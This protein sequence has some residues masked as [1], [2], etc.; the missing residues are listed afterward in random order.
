MGSIRDDGAQSNSLR[1]LFYL[2]NAR[3]LRFATIP[4][5]SIFFLDLPTAHPSVVYAPEWIFSTL[6]FPLLGQLQ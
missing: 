3:C 5:P 1:G 2:L 6:P 4:S